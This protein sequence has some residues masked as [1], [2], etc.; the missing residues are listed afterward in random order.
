MVIIAG[1]TNDISSIAED[2]LPG[3]VER[4]V[5]QTMSESPATYRFDSLDQLRFELMLRKEVVDAALAL[6]RSGISFSTFH[7]SRSNEDYWERLDNGGFKLQSGVSPARAIMDI[8]EHGPAYATECATAMQIVYY[9]AILEV[10]GPEAFN[11][12]FPTIY[13]MNWH[14]L[15]PLIEGV[16]IPRT[17][18]DLLIGDRAYF[19]NPDVDPKVP[20][21]QGEN[22][23]V[24]P[25]G[26]YYGHG[27]GIRTAESMI[28][29]LNAHR[30]LGATKSA[31]LRDVVGRLDYKQLANLYDRS[32]SHM[33][34][35]AHIVQAAQPAQ[36]AAPVQTVQAAQPVQTVQ[37]TQP[38]QVAAPAQPVQ[39]TQPVHL[40]WSPFPPPISRGV[41]R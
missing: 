32:A 6:N 12:M 41:S 33:A 9:R 7:K 13:L 40:V 26:L 3:S 24:M 25:R 34:A 37:A 2:Y 35:P 28:R 4:L 1:N 29:T 30:E 11:R 27:A 36:T 19:S 10:F 17:V 21:W 23:I 8:Y 18:D 39:A 22:V 20:E 14:N 31:Y 38:A 16:G 15:D 5:L